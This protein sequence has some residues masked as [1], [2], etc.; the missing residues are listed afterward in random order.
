MRGRR[1]FPSMVLFGLLVAFSGVPAGEPEV[2]PIAAFLRDPRPFLGE[3]AIFQGRRAEMEGDR[4][5]LESVDNRDQY[6]EIRV[7]KKKFLRRLRYIPRGTGLRVLVAV[8]EVVSFD[9]VYTELELL[10]FRK[11]PRLS[12]GESTSAGDLPGLPG[13]PGSSGENNGRSSQ[14]EEN[15]ENNKKQEN[16]P[17]RKIRIRRR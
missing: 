4:F 17:P 8:T 13:L 12:S 11:L 6:L 15:P 10:D 7:G 9:K 1:F 14:T 2:T 3:S 5:I 16:K